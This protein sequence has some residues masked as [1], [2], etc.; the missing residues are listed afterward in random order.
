MTPADQAK[1]PP[2]KRKR[3]AKSSLPGLSPEKRRRK[4][5]PPDSPSSGPG[6]S[7]LFKRQGK[8]VGNGRQAI[9]ERVHEGPP[10]R[11]P[12]VRASNSLGLFNAGNFCY[13]NAVLQVLFHT[14]NFYRYLGMMHQDCPMG[15]G[16]CVVCMVQDLQFTYYNT[17]GAKND[18]GLRCVDPKS[19]DLLHKA[20]LAN[21]PTGDPTFANELKKSMQSDAWDFVR[22]LILHQIRRK[23]LP[24]DSASFR[25]TFQL[26]LE[27]S[28]TCNDCE[29]Q[30]VQQ[31]D[32][33]D[34]GLPVHL[35]QDGKH[36]LDLIKCLKETFNEK[37]NIHCDSNECRKGRSP[38]TTRSNNKPG[39]ERDYVTRIKHAPQIL[40]MQ[41]RRFNLKTK[42]DAQGREKVVFDRQGRTIWEKI[43]VDVHFP[44][45][46]N[47]NNLSD[48]DDDCLYRL[49]GVVA[50][51][52][53]EPG[54]GHYVAAVRD[55]NGF[56]FENI[57]D[58]SSA[59][60]PYDGKFTA[61]RQPVYESDKCD[62][63]I[64]VYSKM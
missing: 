7:N 6:K 43:R 13:Q 19:L 64:L 11:F 55:Y 59:T 36:S 57:S 14:P 46:L 45:F 37:R 58:D 53:A 50:H 12:P 20:C 56:L 35:K 24:G 41:L 4:S 9:P 42:P 31:V 18:A 26:V 61:M 62:P 63:Y 21:L 51:L 15:M 8:Y 16:E 39:P 28:W 2:N 30:T 48:E 54:G 3:S 25:D 34:L 49:D 23:E 5:S 1:S 29:N 60:L 38:R 44:E 47:L 32:S 33:T 27:Q 40:L 17:K 52:G 22:Y 10:R